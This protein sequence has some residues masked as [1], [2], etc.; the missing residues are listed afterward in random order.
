MVLKV[1]THDGLDLTINVDDYNP[2]EINDKLNDNEIHT[3]VLGN[4]IIS[5]IN[6]KTIIPE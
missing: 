3:V 4:V 6:V 1:I 5:R 2:I